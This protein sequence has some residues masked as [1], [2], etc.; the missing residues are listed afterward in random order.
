MI[1]PILAC[2][3]PYKSAEEF[4]DA[5]WNLDFSQPPESGDPL[6]G[7]SLCG[8]SILLGVAE[9]YVTDDQISHIGCGVVTYISVPQ[10]RIRGI[11]ERHSKLCPTELMVQPWGDLTFEVKIS[12]YQFMIAS[13]SEKLIIRKFK[14]EDLNDLYHLLSDDEVMK[15]LEEP[16]DYDKT[17]SFLHEAALTDNPLIYAVES[18]N[19]DFIGYVIYHPYEEDSYEIGWV[20]AGKHWGKGYAD[21]L[22]KMLINESKGKTKK[23]VIECTPLQT[24]TKR[25]AEK[26]GFTYIGTVDGLDKYVLNIEN[27]V[28][29]ESYRK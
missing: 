9:G 1:K 3:D 18:G 7:V 27:T 5:G 28:D 4:V 10:N 29:K 19:H 21:E 20:I 14:E 17:S 6:V 12:G 8:N 15:Y 16:F 22:T 23:L 24:A 2:V 11:Y 13:L 26:N 25:I